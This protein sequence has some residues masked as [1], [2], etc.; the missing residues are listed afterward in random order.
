MIYIN[1]SEE[2]RSRDDEFMSTNYPVNNNILE[3][4]NTSDDNTLKKICD[5]KV[6]VEDVRI[7]NFLFFCALPEILVKWFLE[8]LREYS[9]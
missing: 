8:M 5:R 9:F 3:H 6:Y 2:S 4:E 1:R 7:W